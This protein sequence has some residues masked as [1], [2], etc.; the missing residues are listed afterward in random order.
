MKKKTTF[1]S[2]KFQNNPHDNMN[3][4]KDTNFKKILKAVIKA[5]AYENM[6]LKDFK[7]ISIP[8]IKH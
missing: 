3:I 7:K 8:V 6:E 4:F 5:L 1:N 2:K